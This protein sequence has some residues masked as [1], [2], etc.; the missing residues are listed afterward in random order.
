MLGNKCLGSFVRGGRSIEEVIKE[1][2]ALY[3]KAYYANLN[4]FK[5]K[6]LSKEVEL[7][8]QWTVIS[9]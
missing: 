2:I 4:I 5:C 8:L 6:L 9:L 3:S 1:R 7:K